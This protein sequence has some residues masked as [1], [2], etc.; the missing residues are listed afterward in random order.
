MKI[1]NVINP[2]LVYP[3]PPF[4]D[5]ILSQSFYLDFINIRALRMYER[6]KGLKRLCA[7]NSSKELYKEAIHKAITQ[8]GLYDPYTGDE[9]HY[10]LL[11]TWNQNRAHSEGYAY[12]VQFMLM[13]TVDHKDPESEILDFEICSWQV[14]TCKND[15]NVTDFISYCKKIV[16]NYQPNKLTIFKFPLTYLLPSFLE[17]VCTRIVFIKWLN[18]KCWFLH[19]RDLKNNKSFA[20]DCTRLQ[21]KEQ[22]YQSV[23]ETGLID[24]YTG[25]IMQYELIGKWDSNAAKN[26]GLAYSKQFALLPTADHIDPQGDKLELEICSWRV[27]MMKA[28]FNPTDFISFCSKVVT[29]NKFTSE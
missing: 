1:S 3:L 6:D 15:L 8:T 11:L 9:M 2:P 28:D 25:D 27:N 29:N 21:Y 19:K 14:N 16:S 4:L 22:I 24:P 26:G 13:P 10:D 20:A 7:I 23:N 18:K 17:N 5:N 12:R